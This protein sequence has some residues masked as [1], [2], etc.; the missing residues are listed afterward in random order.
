MLT[1]PVN[2]RCKQFLDFL[3]KIQITSHIF[4]DCDISDEDEEED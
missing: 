2:H 1:Q 3:H 4:D